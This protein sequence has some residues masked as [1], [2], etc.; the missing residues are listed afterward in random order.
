MSKK[1]RPRGARRAEK[2]RKRAKRQ[3]NV[4]PIRRSGPA[5]DDLLDDFEQWLADTGFE[6]DPE[7]LASLSGAAGAAVEAVGQV[8][9]DFWPTRW[10]DEHLEIAMDFAESH[11]DGDATDIGQATALMLALR[12]FVDFLL[13][14]SRWTGNEQEGV[15]VL[16]VCQGYL[17]TQMGLLDPGADPDLDP[18]IERAALNATATIRRLEA[19]VEWVGAGK[20]ATS[21]GYLKPAL[22]RELAAALG[23]ELIVTPRSM[24]DHPVL[25][26]TWT[27]AQA[28]ELI[29]VVDTEALPGPTLD[30]WRSNEGLGLRRAAVSL[31]IDQELN[32]DAPA[33]M[34]AELEEVLR[35]GISPSPVPTKVIDEAILDSPGPDLADLAHALREWLSEWVAEGWLIVDD[36]RYVVP[37]GLRPAVAQVLDE[38]EGPDI[39]DEQMITVRAELTDVSPPVA[40]AAGALADD[41][42][43]FPLHLAAGVRVGERAHAPVPRAVPGSRAPLPADG[44]GG[45]PEREVRVRTR[46]AGVAGR[47]TDRRRR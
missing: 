1:N 3:S 40:S 12:M 44:H 43:R 9:P 21:A 16:E 30:A 4:V 8:R 5:L 15:D 6:Q 24:S 2:T 27:F 14:T 29:S 26:T 20:P 17:M 33:E 39:V 45:A 47:A 42:R 34:A 37:E 23:V 13:A 11:M 32:E 36:G 19:L 35:F 38:L 18:E 25:A 7:Q 31:A 28:L 46:G 22:L 41:T 10:T